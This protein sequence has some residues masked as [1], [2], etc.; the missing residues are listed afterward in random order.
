MSVAKVI[1]VLLYD[2]TPVRR[3]PDHMTA[4]RKEVLALDRVSVQY[5]GLKG[6]K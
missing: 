2:C 3:N 5:F 6:T 4:R 1:C